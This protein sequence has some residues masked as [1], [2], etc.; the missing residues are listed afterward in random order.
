M[1]ESWLMMLYF[2]R[3]HIPEWVT[4]KSGIALQKQVWTEL[5]ERLER[6]QPGVVTAV[7]HD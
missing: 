2:F 6:I 7:I 4:N 5:L 3:D 1:I